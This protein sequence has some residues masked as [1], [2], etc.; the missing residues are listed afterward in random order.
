[1]SLTNREIADLFERIAN[2]LE[3]KGESV[4]RYLAYANAAE[5]IRALPRDLRAIAAEGGLTDIPKI[6]KTLAAKIE[7]LLDTGKLEFYDKLA[8]EIP[9]SLVEVM[10]INGVGAKKSPPVLG[11]ASTR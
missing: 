2:L 1:M 11:T 8:A 6:G 10:R 9:P 5:S 4:H 7:E 3:I